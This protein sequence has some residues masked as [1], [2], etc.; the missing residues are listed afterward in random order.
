M[1]EKILIISPV[2]LFPG[3]AGNRER[4]RTICTELMNRGYI[5]DFFYAG[6]NDDLEKKHESYFNGEIL[7]HQLE[8]DRVSSL[9]NPGE[10]VHEIVNGL[11]ARTHRWFRR[12]TD[13]SDSAKFNR[14]LYEYKNSGKRL[15][16]KNQIGGKTYKAV[17]LN[18]APYSFYFDLFD[19][20][21][22]RII[23]AH[24]RLTDR[25]K[26]FSVSG[27]SENPVNWHSLRYRDEKQA[28][29]KA[30][31]VW[32]ITEK[33]ARHFKAMVRTRKTEV[34]T[35]RHL[36]P[37]KKTEC[38]NSGKNLLMIGSENRL[39]LEGLDWFLN[40]VWKKL[41]EKDPDIRFLI[42][43][44]ICKAIEETAEDERIHLLGP[45]DSP[46]EVYSKSEL[47]INPMQTGTG[48]K[49]KTFEALASGKFVLSTTAGA[50]G[51]NEFTGNG[52]LCSD[53]PKVWGR[54]IR[55]FFDGTNQRKKDNEKA[56]E[57]ITEIYRNNLEVISYSLSGSR[58]EKNA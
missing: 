54:E 36:M 24:D 49:I 38:K 12:I 44:S 28:I 41:K 13:G 43:G 16:L 45:F 17:L 31:I 6:F 21:T 42:A 53:D 40:R 22:L 15:L 34:L 37:Y 33:E 29:E 7:N 50:T 5:L 27:T 11:K 25:Y 52:L 1:A 4:I 18:Y 57:L 10:R 55:S 56:K 32:A 3:H 58:A 9:K 23:D 20:N 30:D 47:F 48:L 51:L 19:E 14:S 8:T 2:P 35:L 39:N 26:L 46:A